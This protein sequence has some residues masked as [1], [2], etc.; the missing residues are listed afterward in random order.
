[1]IFV[2]AGIALLIVEAPAVPI[3]SMT[4]V[5]RFSPVS[6]LIV[7]PAEKSVT[8]G[9]LMLVEPAAAPV[10]RVVTGCTRKSLQ[11][12]SVSSPSG[13]RPAL[14]LLA[15]TGEEAG[16]KPPADAG[17]GTRQPF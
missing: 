10:G 14:L 13:K 2:P 7:W 6:T 15:E 9:T 5:S 1:M 11:L 3:V 8:L 17:A 16:P 12:L 4:A